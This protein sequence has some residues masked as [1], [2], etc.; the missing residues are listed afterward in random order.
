MGPALAV[1]GGAAFSA[2]LASL[3]RSKFVSRPLLVGCYPPFPCDFSFLDLIH[4]GKSAFFLL[5]HE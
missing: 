3:L 4:G 1:G 5:C 2:R